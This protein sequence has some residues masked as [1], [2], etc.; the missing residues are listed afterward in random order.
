MCGRKCGAQ[1]VKPPEYPGYEAGISHCQHWEAGESVLGR[2]ATWW[3]LEVAEP[4]E[5]AYFCKSKSIQYQYFQ[6]AQ[7]STRDKMKRKEL[8]KFSF[9]TNLLLYQLI[10]Q[11]IPFTSVYFR[12]QRDKKNK[13]KVRRK[14]KRGREQKGKESE[15]IVEH[16]KGSYRKSN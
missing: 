6:K 1:I 2:G 8:E 15:R 13:K 7:P 10:C 11:M 16:L 4:Y 9:L 12:K 3:T 14:N 5:F